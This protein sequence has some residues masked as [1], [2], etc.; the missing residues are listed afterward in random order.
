MSIAAV[1]AAVAHY[2][3]SRNGGYTTFHPP[4]VDVSEHSHI[5]EAFPSDRTDEP[6]EISVLPWRSQCRGSILYASRTDSPMIA[7]LQIRIF[8]R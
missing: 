8:L 4:Q 6:L 2:F 1:K 7:G 5:V 3:G